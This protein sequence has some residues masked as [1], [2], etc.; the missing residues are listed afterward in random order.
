MA[1]DAPENASEMCLYRE[2]HLIHLCRV[3]LV[4]IGVGMETVDKMLFIMREQTMAVK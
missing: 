2:N 1:S 3:H 4:V